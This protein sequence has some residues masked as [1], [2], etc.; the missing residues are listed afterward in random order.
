MAA[1]L[2]AAACCAHGEETPL[3][4][5]CRMN[6]RGLLAAVYSSTLLYWLDDASEGHSDTWAFLDRRIA[7]VMRIPKITGRWRELSGKLPSP[8]RFMRA[9]R[10]ARGAAAG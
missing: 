2:W 6:K 1:E 3:G 5:A 9:Y 10:R 8:L 7:D 4:L